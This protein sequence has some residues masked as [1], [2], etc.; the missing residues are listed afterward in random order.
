MTTTMKP[1]LPACLFQA[2][3]A[4]C[5]AALVSTTPAFADVPEGYTPVTI[6][7]VSQLNKYQNTDYTAFIIAADITDNAYRMTGAH[8]YWT[9]SAAYSHG[10]TF[11]K[12]GSSTNGGAMYIT[13]ELVEENLKELNFI[14]NSTDTSPQSRGGAIYVED[15]SNLSLCRNGSV[16][17]SANQAAGGGAISAESG[18]VSFTENKEVTF[19]GNSA[20]SGG[21][22]YG[23]N[24]SVITLSG[25][26]TA[27]LCGNS[28]KYGG[29]IYGAIDST[30]NVT[31]NEVV[32]FSGNSASYSGGAIDAFYGGGASFTGNGTMMF[33]N[34][35]ADVKGGAIEADSCTVRVL[36]NKS[37]SFSGNSAPNGGAIYAVSHSTVCFSENEAITFRGNSASNGGAIYCYVGSTI[38][39]E[40]N[41]S[42]TFRGNYEKMGNDDSATYRLRSMYMGGAMFEIEYTISPASLQLAAG[43]GQN[44]T[45]YD[46][47]Y[48]SSSAT[49]SLNAQ[50]RDKNGITQNATGD[51]VFSG[52]YAEDDLAELNPNY[53][54]QELMDSLT[55]EVY[56]TT[57]L[58]GGRLRIE[59]GA[60]YKGNGI[61]VETG[62]DATLRLDGGTLNVSGYNV[63]LNE[64]T[65]LEAAGEDYIIAS[66]LDL[67]DGSRMKL[68][69][70]AKLD[71]NGTISFI[72][73]QE[74]TWSVEGG[75]EITADKMSG[76]GSTI[77]SL[78]NV[79]VDIIDDYTIENMSISGSVIDIS[80]GTTLYV[81]HVNIEADA[82]I[83]DEA[84]WLDMVD[85]HGWL[86]NT[87][88]EAAAPVMSLGDTLYYRAG[89]DA[90]VRLNQDVS[91]VAMTSELFSNVTLTGS[92]L[93]LDLTGL[94]D[95]IGNAQAFSIAFKDALYD[96]NGLRVV[97]TVDG[98]HYLDGYYTTKQEGATTTLYFSSQIPEPA[99]ST[100][101]LLALAALAARRK[102]K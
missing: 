92:D 33:N 78:N 4:T 21:A 80:E 100:L 61:E 101:S 63:T 37:V 77:S 71:V 82:R 29:A 15:G 68:A 59:D 69:A 46:T 5:A 47:L 91:Y 20:P 55:T 18:T 32:S 45:F 93:W 94:A 13:S 76:N 49:L 60:I 97:A 25:N 42:V 39:I 12:L 2:L 99:T 74:T 19:S 28:A 36:G 95:T 70:G 62:S 38:S 1:H 10:L 75:A 88:T 40:G 56:E 31:G 98:E 8:Q 102:K 57:Y 35:I 66:T 16:T 64:S 52:K 6:T 89:D 54:Q 90:W 84:A 23:H 7:S 9:D 51:I 22:I 81:K 43:A 87:N 41:D 53:T 72:A 3:L 58:Y 27:T 11:E 86:D 48:A 50:Y 83:T 79:N 14:Q 67:K 85:T 96:V 44:I 30:I 17:F 26:E 65:T 24:N 73:P 34:N